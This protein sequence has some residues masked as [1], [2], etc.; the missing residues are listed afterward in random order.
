MSSAR[1]KRILLL[2]LVILVVLFLPTGCASNEGKQD[3]APAGTG[4]SQPAT[5]QVVTGPQSTTAT[6]TPT[7]TPKGALVLE[8]SPP[9]T[10]TPFVVTSSPTPADL[11]AAATLS[12]WQTA[13]I[14]TTGTTTPPP[15]NLV[16][17]TLTPKPVVVTS[18]PTPANQA[19]AEQMALLATARAFTTGTPI[20]VGSAWQ[21]MDTYPLGTTQPMPSQFPKRPVTGL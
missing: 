4:S 9:A 18:T 10:L 19:T 16:T 3:V 12:A 20:L 6:L 14:L 11:L 7:P 21:S 5:R 1:Q 2:I 8:A 15:P 13:Q 17:A